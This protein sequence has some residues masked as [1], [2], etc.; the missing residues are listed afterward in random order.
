MSDTTPTP[1]TPANATAEGTTSAGPSAG[2]PAPAPETSPEASAPDPTPTTE[3][4]EPSEADGAEQ[5][6]RHAREWERRAKRNAELAARFPDL[7]TRVARLQE[8]YEEAIGARARIEAEVWRER[9]ARTHGIPDDLLDLLAG[10]SET[11]VA[12]RAERIAAQLTSPR[13]PLPD[14]TQGRGAPPPASPADAFATY[15]RNA[16]KR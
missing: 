1:S 8:Q 4:A 11:E 13:R 10:A 7:E 15:V 2:L 5:W 12:E 6:K 9:A 16:L 14:P 3:L